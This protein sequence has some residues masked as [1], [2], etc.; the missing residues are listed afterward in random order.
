MRDILLAAILA[1]TVP[2]AF[3][4]WPPLNG[5]PGNCVVSVV[6]GGSR[7]MRSPAFSPEVTST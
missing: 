6:M 2:Y 1:V 4:Y 3:R 5:E 7:T